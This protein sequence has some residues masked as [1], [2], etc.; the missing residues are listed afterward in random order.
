M[1]VGIFSYTWLP[2]TNVWNE[3]NAQAMGDSC[4]EENE[5]LTN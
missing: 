4:P 2:V 1:V 5:K 3:Q